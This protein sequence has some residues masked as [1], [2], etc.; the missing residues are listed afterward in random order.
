[1]VTV[2]MVVITV[3]MVKIVLNPAQDIAPTASALKI[4]N[5]AWTVVKMDITVINATAHAHIHVL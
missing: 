1:M 5:F 2:L 4:L 3:F